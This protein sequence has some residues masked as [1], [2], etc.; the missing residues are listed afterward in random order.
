LGWHSPNEEDLYTTGPDAYDVW[1]A[2]LEEGSAKRDGT[3]FN[4]LV[5]H[6]CR[7]QAVAFLQ[8]ARQ[9]LT[10]SLSPTCDQ[11]L[12]AAADAYSQVR[13]TLQ[14]LTLLVPMDMAIWDG[15]TPLR[16]A[17][18]ARLV[19][20]AGLAERRALECLQIALTAL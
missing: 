2:A 16:S 3:S 10:G 14:A 19:R 11:A 12:Q 9:R 20:Q 5:W 1:A 7:A 6:E 13:D 4:A 17:E 18:A 8:E 15:A